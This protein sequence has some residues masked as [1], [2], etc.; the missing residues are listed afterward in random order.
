MLWV[1]LGGLVLSCLNATVRTITLSLDPFQSQFLRYLFGTVVMLPL[2]WRQGLQSYRPVNMR[3]QFGRGAVHTVGLTLWFMAL[4]HIGLADITAIGFTGPIFIM[5]GASWFLG[6]KMRGDR[7]V[8]ATIGFVGVLVVV[9][10]RL[11]GQGGW[12]ALVMLASCPIFAASFLMTKTLTR[13]E[14]SGV[15][16]LWQAISVTVLSLPLGLLHWS[17]PTPLQWLGFV[18]AGILGSLGQYC[19]TRGFRAADISATQSL[20]FL[21]L[22]WASLMGWMVFSDVPSQTTLIGALVILGSTI[23]I[24]RREHGRRC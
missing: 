14:K 15:I 7:W 19:L 23:W 4:P 21:D 17:A 12:Y 3:G 8:A 13:Y 16:V 22:I 6:E 9:A 18:L 11:T 10:P 1:A 2:V 20:R 24:A 5:L